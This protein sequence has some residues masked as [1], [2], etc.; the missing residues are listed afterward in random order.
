MTTMRKPFGR[1]GRGLACGAVALGLGLALLRG[2]AAQQ[3]A[4]EQQWA[5]WV[6]GANT[7]GEINVVVATGPSYREGPAAFGKA[8]P[9]IKTNVTGQHIRDALPRILRERE[10][11]IYSTDVMIGAV[12]AGVFQEWIPK[13]VLAELKPVLIRPDV[14]DDSKWLCGLSWGWMDKSKSHNIGFTTVVVPAVFVNR[15][16]VPEA[17]MPPG[18][19]LDALMGAKWKGKMSWSD[20]RELGSGQ[21]ISAL[22]LQNRGEKFLRDFITGQKPIFTRDDRQ[23]VE[24]TIRSRYPVALGLNPTILAD[25]QKDGLGKNVVALDVEG[26]NLIL[27]GFGVLAIFDKAPHPNAAKIFANWILTAEG[28]DAYT[29]GTRENSR[30]VDVPT[31]GKDPRPKAD[32]C[33]SAVDLQ[34]EEFA[35]LR[36]TSGKISAEAFEQLR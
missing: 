2:A 8:F 12:G 16:T 28:Q 11:G 31:Y 34:K 17:D 22:F 10:A 13:G 29:K 4:W 23:Q 19:P 32:A 18:M 3:A 25:F 36:N 33:A 1:I 30:R 20:P 14:T 26:V 27:P 24:W 21:N 9:G 15:D 5:S 7:E 6:E 35:V